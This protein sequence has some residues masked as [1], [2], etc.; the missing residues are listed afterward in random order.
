[1]PERNTRLAMAIAGRGEPSY[2]IAASARINPTHLS[3]CVSGRVTP[4]PAVRARIAE[5]LGVPEH[6]LFASVDVTSAP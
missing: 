1:M 5:A 2:V 3:G 6:E 4:T